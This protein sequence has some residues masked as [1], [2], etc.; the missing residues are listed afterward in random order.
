M[1]E[2]KRVEVLVD[3]VLRISDIV[4]KL[5]VIKAAQLRDAN[6]LPRITCMMES[7]G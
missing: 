2:E 1:R 6:W 5:K 3:G 4:P 7:T